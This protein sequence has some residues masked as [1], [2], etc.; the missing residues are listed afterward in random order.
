M[1]AKHQVFV[2]STFQDLQDERRVV[3]EQILN[4]GNIPVGMELFQAAND[5]QWNYIK[6]RIQDCDYFIV[7]IAERYGS[8]DEEGKSFTRRE[9]EY[10]L[11]CGVPV[12][13]FLL[14]ESARQSWPSK[15]V[16][17]S[18]KPELDSFREFASLKLCKFWSDARDLEI[19]AGHSLRELSRDCPRPGWIKADAVRYKGLDINAAGSKEASSMLTAAVERDLETA[20]YYREDQ[21]LDIR[22]EIIDGSINIL[23]HFQATIIP[24]HR[25]ARVFHPDIRAPDGVRIIGSPIYSVGD[26]VV[27]EGE[28]Q[29][30]D[31]PAKD[32]LLVRYEL[33]SNDVKVVADFHFWPSPVLKYVV[34]FENSNEFALDVGR[35]TGRRSP[36]KIPSK[37]AS[38]GQYREFVGRSAAL[39]AQGLKWTLN[40]ASATA[41]RGSRNNALM[42][43]GP[44][45]VHK[46]G[47]L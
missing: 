11:E 8:V 1:E 28:D 14:A 9:Y 13:A 36:D 22:V 38:S 27:G 4:M 24:I 47:T 19:Q 37:L 33:I 44:G 34:R 17:H 39:T 23:L 26:I 31:E 2:S 43:E 35:I 6:K 20:G 46:G 5:T 7:I 18:R 42:G 16:E 32:S 15:H 3:M 21:S 12:A 29:S 10:A 41:T 30:I 25:G 45:Q 40:R